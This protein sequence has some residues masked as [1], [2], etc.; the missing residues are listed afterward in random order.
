MWVQVHFP[1]LQISQADWK[2]GRSWEELQ[3][4]VAFPST[5]LHELDGGYQAD[6]PQLCME[7]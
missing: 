7:N 2:F 1:Y 6:V 3:E 5:G 4:S